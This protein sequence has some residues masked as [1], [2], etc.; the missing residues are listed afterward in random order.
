[1]A[2]PQVNTTGVANIYVSGDVT[3]GITIAQGVTLKIWFTGNFSMK[4][5]NIVNPNNNAAFLQLFGITPPAGQTEKV[6]LS[7]DGSGNPI[8]CYFLLDSPGHDF[9]V[10]SN[11]DLFGAIVA[12]SITASGVANL[13]YDEALANVGDLVDF[14]RAMWVEDER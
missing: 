7:D 12:N 5:S 4:S 10:S 8:Q 6:T 2:L 14:K 13:H 9:T 11:P 3:G 1:V